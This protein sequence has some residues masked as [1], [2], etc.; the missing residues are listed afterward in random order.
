MPIYPIKCACGFAGD[1]FSKVA[2]LDAKGRIL[3]PE[4]GR[5]AEQVWEGRSVAVKG[6]ELHGQAR[7]ILDLGCQPHEVPEVRRLFGESGKCW[8]DDGS[9]ECADKSDAKRLFQKHEELKRQFAEEKAGK[10]A[11]KV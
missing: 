10:E 9:V 11:P 4:C 6:D 5:R 3:C 8:K 1:V 7:D 2:D